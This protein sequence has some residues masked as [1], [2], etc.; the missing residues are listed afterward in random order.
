MSQTK[1]SERILR[2]IGIP[3]LDQI[4][5][6]QLSAADL[7]SLLLSVYKNRA[8]KVPINE[9]LRDEPVGKPSNVDA[10]VLN[11]VI[12]RAFECAETFEAI[13][14][15]PVNPLGTTYGLTALDQ[16]NVLSTIRAYECSSDPTHG[17]A[18]E[19]ARRRKRPEHRNDVV[20]LCTSQRVVR[21][22]APTQKGYSAHFNL[23]SMVTA[24]KD[25]GSFT[26]ETS[27]LLEHI[28][29]YLRFLFSL[30]SIGFKF[31][32]IQIELS[33]TRIVQHLCRTYDIDTA[34]I[35]ATVR[36]RDSGSSR[37]VLEKYEKLWPADSIALSETDIPRHF[38]M[39]LQLLEEY[40]AAP[41][42][43]RHPQVPV[44]F[45]LHRLTGIGYYD[46]PC[47]HLKT[48]NKDGN[49]MMLADGG[50]TRWGAELLNDAKERLLTTAIGTELICRL[51]RAS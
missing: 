8:A 32:D 50:F 33:D 42:R 24:G 13:E 29:V 4:L 12:A 34:D 39:Q 26:F 36:A 3:N 16:A 31:N 22:P 37:A 2:Q 1:I 35:R 46:G 14:L 51:F 10:R 6:S 11:T 45:N 20:R 21:F 49:Q 25:R 48:A 28:D 23:F 19:C 47:F 43:K 38:S 18:L 5:S 41:L 30:E 7:H 17:L 44:R 9:L 15:S 27:T 40:V